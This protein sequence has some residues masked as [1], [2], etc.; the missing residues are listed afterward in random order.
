[1]KKIIFCLILIMMLM[2]NIASSLKVKDLD[3]IKPAKTEIKNLED[4]F[5]LNLKSKTNMTINNFEVVD[6]Q[7][8]YNIIFINVL[9]NNKDAAW[10]MRKSQFDKIK[11]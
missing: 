7:I 2:T 6:Y 5:N 9:I 11:K 8:Y 1:M 10:I 3:K 4:Y